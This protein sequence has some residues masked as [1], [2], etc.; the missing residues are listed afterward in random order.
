MRQRCLWAHIFAFSTPIDGIYISSTFD[1]PSWPST[2]L[3]MTLWASNKP[4]HLQSILLDLQ[5]HLL[6]TLLTSTNLSSSFKSLHVSSLTFFISRTPSML[7]R[8]SSILRLD[9]QSLSPFHTIT[10]DL[11]GHLACTYQLLLLLAQ[12][13]FDKPCVSI[14]APNFITMIHVAKHLDG[15]TTHRITYVD[16]IGRTQ[17]VREE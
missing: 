15:I 7:L 11:H 5:H 17:L 10:V 16:V 9:L 1:N 13:A 14:I 6:C 3:H 2:T 4:S 12:S 8:H